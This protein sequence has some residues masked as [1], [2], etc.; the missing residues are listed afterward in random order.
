IREWLLNQAAGG[1]VHYD[2]A[3]RKYS[4]PPEHAVALADE[5]SPFFAA[6]GFQS[7]MALMQAAPKMVQKFKDGS[8]LSWSEQTHDLFEGTERFFKP[9]YISQLVSKWIPS[10]P[11]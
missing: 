6:G 3:T 2:P 9:A 1:Y 4:L 10:V 8:G 7:F 11:G 5:N